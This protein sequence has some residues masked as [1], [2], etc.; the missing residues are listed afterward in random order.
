MICRRDIQAES[1]SSNPDVNRFPPDSLRS[2]NHRKS[3]EVLAFNLH[4]RA[5]V[6]TSN[7][8]TARCINAR[9]YLGICSS[10]WFQQDGATVRTTI[11]A[12]SWPKSRFGGS[13][14]PP[15]QAPVADQESGPVPLDLILERSHDWAQKKTPHNH[16]AG[17]AERNHWVNRP[18]NRREV[19]QVVWGIR[20]WARTCLERNGAAFEER[21]WWAW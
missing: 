18:V 5:H 8:S 16:H 15:D 12:R 19:K 7:R 6:K 3:L 21:Q 4:V 9:H 20:R 2:G 10:F 17:W 1:S 13:H 11:R 14:Q